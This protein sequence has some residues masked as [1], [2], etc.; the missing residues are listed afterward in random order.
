MI[1]KIEIP[2]SPKEMLWLAT[3][4]R[5]SKGEGAGSFR[6]SAPSPILPLFVLHPVQPSRLETP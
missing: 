5:E 3:S 1:D 6:G 4:N 2:G